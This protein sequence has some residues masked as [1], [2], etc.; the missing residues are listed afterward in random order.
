[1][2]D[3]KTSQVQDHQAAWKKM[4]DDQIGRTELAYAEMARIQEQVLTHNKQAIDDMAKLTK[5]SVDYFAE[6]S[7]QWRKLTLEVTRKA[8]DLASYKA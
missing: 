3:T 2:S 7:S 6:L 4:V 8:V 1:M 5:D